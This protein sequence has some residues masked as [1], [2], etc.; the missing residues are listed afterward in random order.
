MPAAVDTLHMLVVTDDD[1]TYICIKGMQHVYTSSGSYLNLK[2]MIESPIHGRS[3]IDIKETVRYQDNQSCKLASLYTNWIQLGQPMDNERQLQS[4]W[5]TKDTH[6][7]CLV[8]RW[9]I[10][11]GCQRSNNS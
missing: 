10:L 2:Q 8:N 9:Q 7:T 5:L 1:V 3:C 4:L 6:W 11:I